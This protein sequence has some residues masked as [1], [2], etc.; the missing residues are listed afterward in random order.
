MHLSVS[1]TNVSEIKKN[2]TGLQDLDEKI[3]SLLKEKSS[4]L[5]KELEET[6]ELLSQITDQSLDYSKLNKKR[7]EQLSDKINLNKSKLFYQKKNKNTKNLTVSNFKKHSITKILYYLILI[8]LVTSAIYFNN[9]FQQFDTF[10]TNESTELK[11]KYLIENLRGD[12]VEIWK[13]WRIASGDTL[14]INIINKNVLDDN[15]LNEIVQTITSLK[16]IQVDN[17]LTAK[18]P[19]G[20]SSTF[21]LGWAGAMEEASK[22]NTAF[23]VPTEFNIIGSSEGPGDIIITFT[24]LIDTDGYVGYT[25]S[26]VYGDEILKSFIT[27]YDVNNLSADKLS[28][29]VRHEFGHALGLAHSSAPEDLMYPE[30]PSNFPF[31][32][33]CNVDAIISLYDDYDGNYIVCEK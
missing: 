29:I 11:S 15:K 20:T 33:E 18:G 32:S 6:D 9:S 28:N 22:S 24:D 21:Y 5:K 13:S 16:T 8:V 27:I 26:I 4:F 2:E 12:K 25:K 7:T 19:K 10:Y 31:I 30:I 3:Y 23:I 17:S 1:S 14:N